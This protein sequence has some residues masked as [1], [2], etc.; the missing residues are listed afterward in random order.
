MGGPGTY[1]SYGSGWANACNT[2]WRL[3]KHYTHEGGISTPLVVHWPDRVRD[4]GAIRPQVGHII[5]LLPTLREVAAPN[6]AP[7]GDPAAPTPEGTS[8]LPAF[9]GRPIARDE[10]YWEHEG[11]RAVRN[12]RWKLV[13]KR[14]G[15]WELYD[16]DADRVELHDLAG[17]EPDRVRD[18]EGRWKAWARRTRVIPSPFLGASDDD[19]KP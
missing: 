5:D 8:L 19:R 1:H 14:G 6:P 10:L 7:Q 11:N 12:G 15:P 13:A 3:Y 9:D 2:P 17:R 4:R 16:L 18:L